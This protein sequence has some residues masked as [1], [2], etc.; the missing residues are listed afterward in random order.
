MV[1]LPALMARSAGSP[2]TII[3]LIDGPVSEA[4][5]S[6]TVRPFPG[7]H[8]NGCLPDDRQACEHGTAIASILAVPRTA[9]PPGICPDCTVLT[10]PIFRGSDERSIRPAATGI[11]LAAAI[12]GCVEG[13]ARIINL[14]LAL[15]TT[16]P[17]SARRLSAALDLAASRGVL[18]VAAAGN[19]AQ[20]GSTILTGHPG[21]VP[22][23]G[24]DLDGRVLEGCSLS[25]SFAWRGI[26]APG[27]S[28]ALGA[29]GE[30]VAVHGTSVAVPFV[31]GTLGLLWSLFPQASAGEIRRALSP[32]ISNRRRT[33]VP[34][35][36]NAEGALGAMRRRNAG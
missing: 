3:G 23:V 5:A 32:P 19:D 11:E 26:L 20:V 33:L 36:L 28:S 17:E 25:R 30:V 4:A 7:A 27:R 35:L 16:L 21:V 12:R 10:W 22:V 29:Q 2:R 18:V 13:G 1:G 14:S 8:R 6:I 9:S 34:P 24:C 15:S 31:T